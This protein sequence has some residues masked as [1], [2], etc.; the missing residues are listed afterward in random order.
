MAITEKE[1][2]FADLYIANNFNAVKAYREYSPDCKTDR[3]AAACASRLL[4]KDEVREYI[5]ERVESRK[6]E[7]GVIASVD[8]VLK[9][10]TEVMNGTA[11]RK[12]VVV[13]NDELV[14]QDVHPTFAES[15]RGADGLAKAYGLEKRELQ[16][17]V[18]DETMKAFADMTMKERLDTLR[19]TMKEIGE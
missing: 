8:E 6:E 2:Y 16:V 15:L 11:T 4:K 5:A 18:G 10:Y 14:E 7:T 9:F 19:S 3:S 1:K 12:K 13:V 17:D